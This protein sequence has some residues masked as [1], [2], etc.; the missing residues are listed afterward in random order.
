MY[1]TQTVLKPFAVYL[2][3]SL[4]TP[5]QKPGTKLIETEAGLCELVML[6]N[7]GAMSHEET[8]IQHTYDFFVLILPSKIELNPEEM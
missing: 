2:Q 5:S 3:R 6:N 1:R 7:V 8:G 4:V